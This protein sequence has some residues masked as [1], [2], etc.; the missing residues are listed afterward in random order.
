MLSKWAPIVTMGY[1]AGGPKCRTGDRHE[2]CDPIIR[3]AING[4]WMR[5]GG[6][7]R[8]VSAYLGLMPGMAERWTLSL[9]FMDAKSQHSRM[10]LEWVA[11]LAGG[12]AVT[13][14]EEETSNPPPHTTHDDH[15]SS[16]MWRAEEAASQKSCR[17]RWSI[18]LLKACTRELGHPL[19]RIFNL[20]LG[21]GKGS[22][23]VEDILNHSSPLRNHILVS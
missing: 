23:A 4:T 22:P 12:G 6:W 17:S 9:K 14:T 20:S 8:A 1:R 18:A 7:H 15:S 13:S 10:E 21:Q 3:F 19:Q 5:A 11:A 16:D 2:I